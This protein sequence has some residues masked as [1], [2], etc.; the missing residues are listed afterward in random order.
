MRGSKGLRTRRAFLLALLLAMLSILAEQRAAQV[1]TPHGVAGWIFESDGSTQVALGTPFRVNDTNTSFFVQDET[2]VPVPG[3]TGRYSVSVDGNDG[4]TVVVHSWK[5]TTYGETRVMLQGDMDNVNVTINMTRPPEANVTITY[6]N[7][8]DVINVSKTWQLNATF[9]LLGGQNGVSCNISLNIS[10]TGIFDIA[11]GESYTKQLGNVNLGSERKVSFNITGKSTGKTNMSVRGACQNSG[12]NFEGLDTYTV[13]NVT[14]SGEAAPSVTLLSPANNTLNISSNTITFWYQVSHSLP[15]QNC[16]LVLNSLD[17]ET[18][19]TVQKDT[20]QNFTLALPNGQYNW[21]VRCSDAAGS[22]GVGKIY[23]LSVEVHYPS[24][25]WVGV[26]QSVF[27]AAG[28]SVRVECNA[29]VRDNNGIS[30]VSKVNATLYSIA[31][32]SE[33]SADNP[34]SHYSNSSCRQTASSAYEANYTC[35]FSLQYFAE[36][37]TWECSVR[38]T[39]NESHQNATANTTIVNDLVAISAD[40]TLDYGSVAAGDISQEKNVTLQ[41]LGNI[42]ISVWV[43]G[44]GT[45]EGDNRSMVCGLGQNISVGNERYSATKNTPYDAK[46]NLTSQA[47]LIQNFSLPKRVDA[48]QSTWDINATFWSIKVPKGMKISS[49]NGSIVFYASI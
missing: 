39:D 24:V 21:T 15:I 10:D 40:A 31:V 32:S 28:Q 7:D 30:D 12:L 17:N 33:F 43:K 48:S 34:N 6:P 27:L 42:N 8:N 4:D 13:Y 20:P 25:A 37:G 9:R 38:A 46:T 18:D 11:A 3:Y 22:S 16:T 44:Y 49:C 35:A 41:N 2:S 14:A 5:S 1:P 23:N 29:S 47:S 26:P 36:N 45:N 19:Y